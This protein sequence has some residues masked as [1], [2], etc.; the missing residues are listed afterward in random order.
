MLGSIFDTHV[1]NDGN[2]MPVMGMGTDK[3]TDERQAS[4]LEQSY[5][6]M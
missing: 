2:K 3:L 1:L 5:F 6:H 4:E